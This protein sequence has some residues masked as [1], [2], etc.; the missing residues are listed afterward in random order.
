MTNTDQSCEERNSE[1]FYDSRKEDQLRKVVFNHEIN[2]WDSVF[3]VEENE[4]LKLNIIKNNHNDMD[5]WCVDFETKPVFSHIKTNMI[6]NIVLRKSWEKQGILPPNVA[7]KNEAK[8]LSFLLFDKYE[9]IPNIVD[10]S[11]DGGIYIRYWNSINNH[12]LFVEIYN[13]LEIAAVV[14]DENKKKILASEN[15]END[16]FDNIIKYFYK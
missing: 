9:L 6:N 8:K 5:T 7:C 12:S 3:E 16:N 11:I 15:I 14:N 10:A 4:F 13:D 1:T 2:Q